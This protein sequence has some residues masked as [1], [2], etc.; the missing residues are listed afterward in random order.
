MMHTKKYFILLLYLLF[1]FHNLI[2]HV[3]TLPVMSK[4]G[5]INIYCTKLCQVHPYLSVGLLIS[6]NPVQLFLKRKLFLSFCTSN[7]LI[8][9]SSC[10][11]FGSSLDIGGH[12]IGAL[13]RYLSTPEISQMADSISCLQDDCH[14]MVRQ[15]NLERP[16]F[17]SIVI[18]GNER[19]W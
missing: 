4:L 2:D 1:F 12:I 8:F 6:R 13:L 18:K 14:G 15:F 16:S 7:F 10:I 19:S 17:I 9:F 11:R 5:F 3:K